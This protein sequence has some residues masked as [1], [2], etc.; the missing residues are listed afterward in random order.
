MRCLCCGNELTTDDSSNI[1]C[2]C[3]QESSRTKTPHRCPACAETGKVSRPPW[4]GGDVDTWADNS[5]G[6]LYDCRACDGTGIVWEP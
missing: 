1:C 6:T 4:V 2:S 3:L 5:A